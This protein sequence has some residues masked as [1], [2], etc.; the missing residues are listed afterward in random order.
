MSLQLRVINESKIDP[1]LDKEIRRGLM[2]CFPDDNDIFSRTRRFH[3]VISLYSVI[4]EQNKT[5]CAHLIIIDRTILIN[6]QPFQIAGIGNVYVLPDHRGKGLSD[7]ILKASMLHAKKI[8]FD[9]GLLF[10]SDFSQKVYARN[11]WKKTGKR[12][13]T[14]TVNGQQTPLPPQTIAMYHPLKTTVFPQGPIDLQG[15]V[16]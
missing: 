5:V 10:A 14:H 9:F 7:Q 11:S 6:Q 1:A 13:I 15:I 12:K 2:I 8:G 3:G 16:W 4:I